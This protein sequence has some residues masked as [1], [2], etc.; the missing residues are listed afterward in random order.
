MPHNSFKNGDTEVQM[1]FLELDFDEL[2]GL[3]QDKISDF[4][5]F[6]DDHNFFHNEDMEFQSRCLFGLHFGRII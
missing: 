3:Y 5:S 4:I 6:D 1:P 2:F